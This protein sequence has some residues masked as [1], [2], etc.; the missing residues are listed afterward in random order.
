MEIMG[1]RWSRRIGRLFLLACVVGQAWAAGPQTTSVQDIVYRA[2]GTAA[3]GSLVITW[4]AFVT[5]DGAAVAAGSKTVTLAG[6]GSFQVGLAPN[7]GATPTNSYYAVTYKLVGQATSKE[8][9]VVPSASPAKL[10]AVRATTVPAQMA[11]QALS[12]D[13]A[14][15]NL[16]TL[17]SAQSV[18]GQKTFSSSPS[19]PAP[20]NGND[21][22]NKQYVD[23]NAAG[24]PYAAKVNTQNTWTQ[25]Q[26]FNGSNSAQ[27]MNGLFNQQQTGFT[28]QHPLNV[29]ED[30]YSG[31]VNCYPQGAGCIGTKTQY[32]GMR[33]F[34]YNRTIGEHKWVTLQQNCYAAGDCVS[35]F[36]SQ[37]D[38][39]GYGTGGDEGSILVRGNVFQGDNNP[40]DFPQGTVASVSGNKLTGNW[41]SGSN[42]YLGAQR[43]LINTSRGVYSAGTIGGMAYA[44]STCTV[45]GSGTAWAS[46]LGAGN[47]N[48]LFLNLPANDNGNAKWV[49]GVASVTDETHLVIDYVQNEVASGCP[50]SATL[51][52]SGAYH[53]YKG[54]LVT[55][56]GDASPAAGTNSLSVVV[57]S[58][59]MFQAGD[60]IQ[61]AF[62]PNFFPEGLKVVMG[63]LIGEPQ[64]VGVYVTNANANPLESAMRINGTW[65]N[66]IRFMNGPFTDGLMAGSFSDSVISL[67]DTSASSQNLVKVLNSGGVA[68]FLSYNRTGDF[69][70]MGNFF[71][72]ADGRIGINSNPQANQQ[73]YFGVS[74][75]NSPT[76][77]GV[78][79][80]YGANPNNGVSPFGV[81]VAGIKAFFLKSAGSGVIN[82]VVNNGNAL[83][84]YSGNQSGLTAT[85]SAATGVAQLAATKSGT[86][87]NSDLAGQIAISAANAGSYTFAQSWATAPI[88]TATPTSDPTAAGAYWVTTSN[89]TL[90]VNVKSAA[91]LTFN[92][93]CVGRT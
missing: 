93:T 76:Y 18:S 58:T 24:G 26:T 51:A 7:V 84:F 78:E 12:T 45:T 5:S 66:G 36:S 48:D 69:F 74:A 37:Y 30:A 11:I 21:A 35:F 90:T 28:V 4:P 71:A 88:C 46:T 52:T 65:T 31:G 67:N 86:S 8:T 25:S 42:A 61:E 39:G 83:Q 82:T 68:R 14:N 41:T 57:P 17:A 54:G 23:Q 77:G 44:N 19:V 87:G 2:D 16:M 91:T 9:W 81:D 47:H 32:S 38:W 22:A 27:Q 34:G 63:R 29:V 53:I 49:V 50:S 89:T 72:S 1:M 55:D 43:P 70:G 13:W 40:N 79:I 73:A 85:I 59:A 6:D 3:N 33:G 15:A 92:Y 80:A 56:V 20:V 62:N 75:G 64:G 10:G 60:S